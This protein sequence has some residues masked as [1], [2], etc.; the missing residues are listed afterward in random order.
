MSR[1]LSKSF[2]TPDGTLWLW[3]VGEARQLIP[4]KNKKEFYYILDCPWTNRF[5]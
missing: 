2:V 5:R 3:H 4:I 1:E